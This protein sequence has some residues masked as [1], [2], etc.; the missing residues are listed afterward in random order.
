MSDEIEKGRIGSSFDDFLREEKAESAIKIGMQP[1]HPGEFIRA[2]ILEEL[3]L[4]T[5]KAAEI[6]DV[7]REVLTDLVNE[8][9]ALS[10]EMALRIE[11]AFGLNMEMMLRMQAR[12]DSVSIR[13]RAAEFNVQRYQ[14]LEASALTDEQSTHES[15]L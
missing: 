14:S 1:V 13:E 3:G 12:Y 6:L 2:E 4:S 5:S 11:M 7:P 9:A 15:D 8:E 10:P